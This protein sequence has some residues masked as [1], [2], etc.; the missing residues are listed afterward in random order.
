MKNRKFIVVAFM[1][2]ACMIVGVG[3][4]ALTDT[5]NF[6]GDAEVSKG[7]A[8]VTFDGDVYFT[9]VSEGKGYTASIDQ[10]DNDKINFKVTGLGGVGDAI[11]ITAT[12]YNDSD[13]DAVVKLDPVNTTVT[14]TT[15]FDAEYS[16]GEEGVQIASKGSIEVSITIK[17]IATPHLEENQTVS[18]VFSYE[19]DVASVDN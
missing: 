9:E 8:E 5:L 16:I 14:N 7:N 19:L 3:Y 11:T 12:I 18:C 1:L 2:I 15:Y 10:N 4:A 13:L 6:A 17:M